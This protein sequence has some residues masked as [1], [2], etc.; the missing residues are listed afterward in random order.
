MDISRAERQRKRQMVVGKHHGKDHEEFA[1][2]KR[3]KDESK[4]QTLQKA[5]QRQEKLHKDNKKSVKITEKVVEFIVLDN[6]PLS[7][8]E[9]VGF[10][11]L[12]EHLEP[13]YSL[14]S[15][16]YISE[17]ALPE[18]Y[19]RVSSHVADQLKDVKSL[20]FTTDIWSSDVYPMTLLSLTA[21]WVNS[22]YA[23]QS[24][25]LHAKELRGPHTSSV[26]SASIKEMMD[27]WK[28]PLSKVHVIL[29]D[30]ASNM[31]KAIKDLGVP[32]LGCVAHS[33]QLVINE[34]LLSQR[35]VSDAL[36]G[37][38]KIVGHFKHSPSSYSSLEDIQ[39]ELHLPVKRLQQDVKT[40]WNS[41]FYM[42][43]SMLEQKRALSAF[44]ADHELPATLTANQWGLLEKTVIV[45]SPF[46]ELTR[47]INSSQSSTADVIPAIVVLKN[48]LSQ[49]R[50]TDSGI[51]T[52]KSTL[53]QAVNERLCNIEDE[54]L[55]SVATLLDPRCKDRYFTSADAVIHAK[56]ALTK[57]AEKIEDTLRTATTAAGPA[58]VSHMEAKCAQ[59]IVENGTTI[60]IDSSASTTN[61]ECKVCINQNCQSSVILK[62]DTLMDFNCSQPE[63]VFKVHIFRDIECVVYSC[64]NPTSEL[65]Q[66]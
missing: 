38:R 19:S 1:Q 22:G 6:Q 42:I 66:R 35:S 60:I 28:I 44:A 23:L 7:V 3:K 45:L 36:A 56:N 50:D 20:S 10:R 54:P 48:L 24:A 41:T 31:K 14:P 62:S 9:N 58:E 26:I 16:K 43:Q 34:G 17:T 11:R 25:V 4:Q 13:R 65:L 2:A 18:L 5:F 29:R 40:R 12:M 55:F 46:E 52:M 21:H 39:R 47:A 33:F 49:E 32:S 8:V 53:L 37:A 15:R 51:K 30:N 57:E 64:S 59:L 27:G 61:S 63:N